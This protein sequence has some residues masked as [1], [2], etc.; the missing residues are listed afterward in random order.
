MSSSRWKSLIFA[1]SAYAAFNAVSIYSVGFLAGKVVPRTIDKGPQASTATAIVVDTVLLTLFALHHSVLARPP[2]KARWTRVVPQHLERSAY[3]LVASL[4]LA[5]TY[6][7]WRPIPHEI[8]DV[9]NAAGRAVL[10]SLYGIGWAIVVAMTFAFDHVEFM[11]LRQVR[12]HG[13]DRPPAPAAFRVPLPYRL[14]RHPMM[15]G[16]FIAFLATP[17]MSAGHVLFAGLSCAYIVVGV[18]FEERDLNR[19]LPE[20]RDYAAATPRFVP[21]VWRRE[22]ALERSNRRG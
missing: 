3:V 1:V 19:S 9:H 8:W 15:T 5:L 12:E 7:Q 2:V 10:W 18:Q 20:Y 11:G 22:P 17:H 6:W 16:F 4:L 21:K 13:S 14:V